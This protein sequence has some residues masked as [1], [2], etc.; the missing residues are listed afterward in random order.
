[1]RTPRQGAEGFRVPLGPGT[2]GSGKAEERPEP[3]CPPRVHEGRDPLPA[4]RRAGACPHR[5]RG[6]PPAAPPASAGQARTREAE[7]R[8]APAIVPIDAEN[9]FR[10]P[11]NP[12]SE[13]R[14][15]GSRRESHPRLP[16]GPPQAG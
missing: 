9:G 2:Q 15:D 10:L 6:S 4:Q 8:P 5:A 3:L 7:E 13:P 11:G 16:E 14:Q 12:L 1:E